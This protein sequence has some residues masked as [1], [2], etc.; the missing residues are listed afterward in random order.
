MLAYAACAFSLQHAVLPRAAHK[1]LGSYK[2][3]AI[4]LYVLL[5]CP[6]IVVIPCNTGFH[7]TLLRGGHCPKYSTR[8]HLMML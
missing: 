2:F 3:F 7:C 8:H 6:F 1:P 4:A 5:T